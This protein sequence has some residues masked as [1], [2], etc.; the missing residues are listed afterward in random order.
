MIPLK[1][2][3]ERHGKSPDNARQAVWRGSFQT[4]QK[5]GRDWFVDEDEPWPDR[6]VKSGKYRDW[7]KKKIDDEHHL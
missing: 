2:Y 4:A 5:I 6:R 3:A 7:R 1:E